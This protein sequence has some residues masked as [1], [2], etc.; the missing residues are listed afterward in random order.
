MRFLGTPMN[1]ADLFAIMPFYVELCVGNSAGNTS[2]L[3]VLRA[4]RL[5]RLFRIFKLGRHSK[6]MQVMAEALRNSMDALWVLIFFLAIGC[7]LFSSLL[8]YLEKAR[9][10]NLETMSRKDLDEYADHCSGEY[11]SFY[12]GVSPKHGLCCTADGSPEDFPSIIS[13]LWW[14]IVTMTTVGFGDTYPRT[15]AGKF[16][17]F[18]AMLVGMILIAVPVAI[19]GNKFQ[20]VYE[21]S[22]DEEAT[23]RSR[24]L[25]KDRQN[26]LMPEPKW[27]LMARTITGEHEDVIGNPIDGLQNIIPIISD[28]ALAESAR[29]ITAIIGSSWSQRGQLRR[30]R[31]RTATKQQLMTEKFDAF[32]DGIQ[33]TWSSTSRSSTDL[34]TGA[35]PPLPPPEAQK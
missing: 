24:K 35:A 21:N 23:Q 15:T 17:G 14:S 1:L 4:V 12:R 2:V 27:K 33:K 22:G 25:M 3:R 13:A 30:E 32:V 28:P 11:S 26:N 20:E 19:V 29:T 10:P 18:V 6:G 7:I 8:Y 9:C 16:V 34:G 31:H 5:V